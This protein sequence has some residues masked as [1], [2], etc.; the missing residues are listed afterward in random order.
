MLGAPQRVS[1][2]TRFKTDHYTILTA[3]PC[4]ATAKPGSSP[5]AAHGVAAT[6][7]AHGCRICFE[8]KEGQAMIDHPHV[9]AEQFPDKTEALAKLKADDPE[10]AELAESYD[11]LSVEIHRGETNIEPMDD[12]HLENLKKRRLTVL[13]KIANRLA[14]A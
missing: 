13:D 10:M 6:K 4:S 1:G 5:H 3:R 14:A 11:A 9:L 2:V 12:F 7:P 8:C